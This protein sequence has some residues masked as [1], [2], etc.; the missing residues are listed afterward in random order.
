MPNMTQTTPYRTRPERERDAEAACFAKV[1]SRATAP[2]FI[3]EAFG[4]IG[5]V[6]RILLDRFPEARLS[7]A[8]LDSE[9]VEIWRRDVLDTRAKIVHEDTCQ[10]LQRLVPEPNTAAVFD[11]NRC[12]LMD[13]LKSGS[14]QSQLLRAATTKLHPKWIEVTDSSV[15]KLHLNWRSYGLDGYDYR[16][17][18]WGLY[19]DKVADWFQTSLGYRMTARSHHWAASYYMLEK[20]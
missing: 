16:E 2:S 10:L 13:L 4:G 17:T 6:T 18:A 15:G 9:C 14:F 5:M 12:T 3:Y 19:S 20:M 8:E 11:F 1:L 7:A